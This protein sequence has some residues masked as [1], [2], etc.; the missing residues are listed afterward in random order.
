[1]VN[2]SCFDKHDLCSWCFGLS[3]ELVDDLPVLSLFEP[4]LWW[5]HEL[6]GKISGGYFNP[7]VTLAVVLSGRG[8]V[9]SRMCRGA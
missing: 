4:E 9:E 5:P 6:Q 1:M 3:D 2:S 8:L 7:A